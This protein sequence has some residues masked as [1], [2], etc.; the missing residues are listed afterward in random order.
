MSARIFPIRSALGHWHLL[1]RDGDAVL[2]DAGFLRAPGAV[3]RACTRAGIL[4]TAIRAVLLTHGHLDH[5]G[6]LSEL[7]AMTG[8]KVLAHRL[9]VPH[10]E[11][12]WSYRGA[13]RM[14]GWLERLGTTVLGL[15]AG[16]VDATFEE[17]ELL[18]FCGG[19]RVVPLPG[20]TVGHCGF[21]LEEERLLFTGDLFANH[22][23]SAHPPP[24]F[25]NSQP[26]AMASSLSRA[27]ALNAERVVPNHYMNGDFTMHARALQRLAERKG[28]QA[29]MNNAEVNRVKSG[30]STEI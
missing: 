4:P 1:E 23:W 21:W 9:E 5:I 19:L 30:S 8:A 12:R 3:E 22:P 28:L 27:A 17:D 11:Q 13:S 15:Q 29:H 10:V 14:C 2:I 25:L 24:Y 6:Y 26:E 18:P 20:H 7:R 16:T